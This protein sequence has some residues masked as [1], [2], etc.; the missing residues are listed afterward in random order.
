M[1]KYALGLQ[2]I[3][4]CFLRGS[5][6]FLCM[7]NFARWSWIFNQWFIHGDFF[8]IKINLTLQQRSIDKHYLCLVFSA[9]S[10]CE[11]EHFLYEEHF[12]HRYKIVVIQWGASLWIKQRLRIYRFF[13]TFSWK[14]NDIYS[15]KS[16]W[17]KE[18]HES[19]R[20]LIKPRI[21]NN[22]FEK[23]S[24]KSSSVVFFNLKNCF[25]FLVFRSNVNV[26]KAKSQKW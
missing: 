11:F 7:I 17:W 4:E 21:T 25:V 23:Y 9:K 2:K 8:Q 10:A 1:V 6:I 19:V 14:V 15:Y 24:G 26:T 20:F 12:M 16:S 18:R 13:D 5:R 3:L 22:S